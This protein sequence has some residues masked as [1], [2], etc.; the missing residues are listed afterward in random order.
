MA[1]SVKVADASLNLQGT[2]GLITLQ[3]GL[4]A[5]PSGFCWLSHH[6]SWLKSNLFSLK[7]SQRIPGFG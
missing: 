4:L 2:T 1:E 6:F 3:P 5:E 7:P